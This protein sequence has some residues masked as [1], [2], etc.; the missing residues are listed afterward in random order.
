MKIQKNVSNKIFFLDFL[1]FIIYKRNLM[2]FQ[3]KL[4]TYSLVLKS[5]IKGI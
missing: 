3:I 5:N 4:L 1:F 2:N